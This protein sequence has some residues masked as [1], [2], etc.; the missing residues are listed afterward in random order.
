MGEG[1]MSQMVV[2]FSGGASVAQMGALNILGPPLQ[3]FIID[4]NT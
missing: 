1:L 4:N 3:D 2:W